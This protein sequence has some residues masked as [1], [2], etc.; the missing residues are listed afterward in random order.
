MQ[1][2]RDAE[3]LTNEKMTLALGENHLSIPAMVAKEGKAVFF[4]KLKDTS[5]AGP[6]Y[7]GPTPRVLLVETQPVL[8]EHLR[9]ALA[10]EN[11]EVEVQSQL[12]SGAE[13]LEQHDLIILSNVPAEAVSKSQMDALESYVHDSG[14]GLIAVGGDRS[15]TVGGYHKT[16]W[17][18]F[19]RC[20]VSRTARRRAYVAM[21]LVLDISGSMNDPVS[22][23]AKER[24]IDLAKEACAAVRKW[25]PRDQVGVLVFKDTSRWIWPLALRHR[26]RRDHC[27]D[28]HHRGRGRDE[29]VSAAGAGV[30]RSA[31]RSPT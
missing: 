8:A 2:L 5:A 28:R 29:H 17:K 30:S 1:V 10:G 22:K 21:V 31:R 4:A 15:F 16:S 23:G 6:I 13:G 3:E 24:N 11:V 27:Q 9:K 20:T 19:C 7:I 12:P 25:A 14:G 26:Q 18:I